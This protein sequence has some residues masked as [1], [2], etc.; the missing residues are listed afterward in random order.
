[1]REVI[2]RQSKPEDPTAASD[3]LVGL[4][5]AGL[6]RLLEK[7]RAARDV[8]FSADESVTTTCPDAGREVEPTRR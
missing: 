6:Q 5:A 4:L 1:M 7:E 8:D 3:R 2:V